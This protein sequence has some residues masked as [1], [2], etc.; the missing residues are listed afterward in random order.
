MN[1]DL[2]GIVH[3]FSS[4]RIYSIIIFLGYF[5][6]IFLVCVSFVMTFLERT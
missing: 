4:I 2:V 5:D 6:S 3:I 1:Y